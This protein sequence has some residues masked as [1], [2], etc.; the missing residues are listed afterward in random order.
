M[1]AFQRKFQLYVDDSGSR[2]PNHRADIN[3]SD[4]MDCFALGGIL[5]DHADL[6][7]AVDSHRAFMDRWGMDYPLHST[8]I[9]GRRKEFSWLGRDERRATLFHEE[10]GQ[11]LTQLPVL[12]V[13]CVIDRPGYNARYKAQYGEDRWLMC[14]TAYSIVVERALKFARRNE[15]ALEVFY[16]GAGQAEDRNLEEYHKELKRRGMPFDNERS[17]EYSALDAKAFTASLLGDAQRV[18]K[19]SSLMQIADLYLYPLVKS[20]YAAGYPPYDSL[21]AASR[22][23]D[24]VL[25]KEERASLGVKYSCFDF[26]KRK[27]ERPDR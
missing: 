26:V 4:E 7:V 21:F 8:K 25:S 23:M 12:G 2:R 9:R 13:A 22:I 18:T 14:K 24:A 27:G 6:A 16:E 19:K 17:T 20:G 11:L 1:E 15:S 3:R 10:L 5:V